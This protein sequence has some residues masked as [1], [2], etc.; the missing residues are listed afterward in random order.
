MG[1][2][3]I[4]LLA[5]ASILA[6]CARAPLEGSGAPVP[7]PKP[8]PVAAP[9]PPATAMTVEQFDTTSVQARTL[10]A[11]PDSGGQRLGT[12]IASLGDPAEPGFWAKTPLVDTV[13]TGRL[14]SPA[15]GASVQVELR[16]LKAPAGAGSQVSLPALRVL[17]VP[18][19]DLP[20][21]IVYAGG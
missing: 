5:V 1:R 6:G 8:R 17:G 3:G 2:N 15:S 16:P 9:A 11:A 21:L 12:T 10:A 7:P 20:E 4:V 19:T 18:L 14:E 13:R